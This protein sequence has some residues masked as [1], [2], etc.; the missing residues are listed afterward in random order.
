MLKKYGDY[1]LFLICNFH[2]FISLF[3]EILY[4]LE[5]RCIGRAHHLE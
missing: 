2:F 1:L 5:L 3:D 4:S